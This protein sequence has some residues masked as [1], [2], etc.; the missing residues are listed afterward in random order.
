MSGMGAAL[1]YA[2]G[3]APLD[4]VDALGWLAA[5]G[6]AVVSEQGARVNR[7]GTLLWSSGGAGWWCASRETEVNGWPISL[8]VAAGSSR[9]ISC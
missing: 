7:L 5:E 4:V 9:C 1:D 3:K 8:L 6:F 2:R